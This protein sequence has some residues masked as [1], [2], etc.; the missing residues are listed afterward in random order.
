MIFVWTVE[1]GE[2]RHY[3]KMKTQEEGS[4]VMRR[5]LL[6]ALMI[7]ATS[8]AS[9]AD[10]IV[11]GDV[12]IGNGIDGSD[13]APV[14]DNGVFFANILG[15][16]TKVLL[17]EGYSFGSVGKAYSSIISF[18]TGLSVTVDV[19]TTALDEGDLEGANLLISAIPLN[20]YTASEITLMSSFLSAGN[21]LFFIGENDFFAQGTAANGFI[22]DALASLGS[23][24][25]LVN[26]NE[27][28]GYHTATGLQIAGNPLTTG[29]DAFV[30]AATSEVSGGTPLFFTLSGAP[31]IAVE[32]TVPE[33]T[34][35][36]LFG[37][38]LGAI[39]LAALRRRKLHLM[40]SKIILIGIVVTLTMSA[41]VWA[42]DIAGKWTAQAQGADITMNF[43]VEGPLLTGTLEN[44]QMPGAIDIK[45]GKIDGDNISFTILRKMGETEMKIVWKGKIVGDEIKFKRELAS[46]DAMTGGPG[47]GAAE[48][49][50]AKRAK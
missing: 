39:A 34:S 24:L 29:I 2:K 26:A 10:T 15:T 46:G 25:S 1:R 41:T 42:A 30:Y 3:G 23:G 40:K 16:G 47:G 13:S 9:K 20:A 36:L 21:T 12:N 49:I 18:Y 31:F 38:G 28:A 22:N 11:S 4:S 37:T 45:D 43:K 19:T 48:E 7:L 33:P 32:A 35:L 5:L 6:G 8:V 17:Q 14:G 44:S 27:D 50:A